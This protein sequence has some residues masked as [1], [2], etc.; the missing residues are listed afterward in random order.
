MNYGQ[1]VGTRT[2]PQSEPILGTAQVPN[3]AGGFAWAVDD[4]T[5]LDRFLILG[6]EGGTYYIT[7]RSLTQ[8]NAQA[9]RRCLTADG[10]RTVARIVDISRAGR[11]PKNDPAVFAL[12]MAAGLGDPATRAAALAAL[13]AVCRIGTH[14]FHFAQAVQGFRGWG[15]GLRGAVGRWYAQPV[16][17]LAYQAIK[18]RQ[19]DGW[20]HADV[21]RLAHARPASGGHQDL[22]NWITGAKAVP[23]A[24]R[25]T[26]RGVR[27]RGYQRHLGTEARTEHPLLAAFMAA[28][29]ATDV[30]QICAL[31]REHDLPREAIP[32]TF[33]NEPDVWAALLERM[34]MTAM[35]RNLAKMTAVG[36]LAPLSDGAARVCAELA[37]LDRLRLAHVHPIAVLA[38]LSI[39]RQGHGERGKLTWTPTAAILDALD[40]AFYAS[41]GNI[42]STGKRRLLALD[43]SASMEGSLIAGVPGL[44]ARVGS[45]A[46]ALV[47]AAVE[48][49]CAIVG[50]ST[51]LVSLPISPRQRLDDVVKTISGLPFG[52]TDCSLPMR[53]ALAT[54]IAVDAFELYTDSETWAGP[55]HPAQ[56]LVQYRQR[57][58]IGA[59]SVVIGMCANEVTIA[60]PNDAGMLD[61]VGFD[62]ATPQVMADFIGS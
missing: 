40:G 8:Q 1:H 13:P 56:A 60:D 42:A 3:S 20:T 25:T 46:M 62:T 15:R 49:Q 45:A 11:A 10:L 5:R 30:K 4:W 14:L 36:L 52:G 9:V 55:I 37:D 54:K 31:I 32:P 6:S 59:K 26:T 44:T 29:G 58:G 18:Y 35:I 12:A 17:H 34:P 28:A 24:E 19:R 50:F 47:T 23:L 48:P 57:M 43:I 53:W 41:F 51:K 27:L 7:E 33:L 2:T 61:I 38:A 22:F 21:L 39:Y 16:D